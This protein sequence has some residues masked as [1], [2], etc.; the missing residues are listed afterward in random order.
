MNLVV[1]VFGTILTWLYSHTGDY[2]IAIVCLT[3]LVKLCLL[4]L[5]IRQRQG[6]ETP[7]AGA[8]SCLLLLLSLPV[9]TGLYRTVLAGVGGSVGSRLCPWVVSLLTRDPYGILPALSAV[10]QILP[11]T[12]PYL[13]FFK[14]LDLPKAPKG[15]VLSSA[16]MVFLICF[17]LPA[18]ASIYYLTSGLFT[19]LEQALQNG[20]CV[21]RLRVKEAE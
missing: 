4:P 18:A 9:L 12:Y 11:Q 14:N 21:Y 17:P 5:Y 15:M 1:T 6:A 8:G 13:A 7:Q 10:V 19:A 20:I 16:L 3:I 2:G